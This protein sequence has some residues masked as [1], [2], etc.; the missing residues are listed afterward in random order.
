MT[1]SSV[2]LQLHIKTRRTTKTANC[3]RAAGDNASF[4]NL[5]KRLCCT[6]DNG[7]RGAGLTVAFA[8]VFQA[9]K[10]SR[11]VLPVTPRARTNG[12]KHRHDVVFFMGEVIFLDLLNDFQ[13][14]LLG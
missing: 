6:L 1:C 3:W 14:L 7:K 13:G 11:H 12:G 10:H 2:V 8:P 5:V 4:F 9:D